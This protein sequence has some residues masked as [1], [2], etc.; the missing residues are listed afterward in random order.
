MGVIVAVLV[1]LATSVMADEP[2]RGLWVV[3]DSIT[4]PESVQRVV[5]FAA[6]HGFNTLFVQVRGRGD[7][8]Y[9]S[10]FVPGPEGYPAIP[11]IF[12]PLAA[13]V[14]AAHEHGIE[15]HAWCNIYLTASMINPPTDPQHLY[16]AHPS[17][18]M[19][20]R[21]GRNMA[22][23]PLESFGDANF[24]GAFL[25]PGLPEVRSY[26]ARVITEVLVS[27]DIDGIHLDY[28]R[29]PGRDFDF[30]YR[31]RLRFES[32]HGIDPLD[33]VRLG[34]TVD[35]TL[36]LA[37]HW[38]AFRADQIDEQVRGIARR[39]LISGRDVALS[40]AVKPD[41]VTAYYEFGQDW[42]GWLEEGIVDFV[43]PMC[44]HEETAWIEDVLSGSLEGVDRSR[45]VGGVGVYKV[46][47][48]VMLEQI[49]LMKQLGLAGYC[50]F[51]YTTFAEDPL[52]GDALER[53][54][55][56]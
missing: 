36:E 56:P 21:D 7:A 53:L 55:T 8:Y 10:Y 50:L 9:R 13:V 33:V 40:A 37:E 1:L 23:D 54:N 47:P 41:A 5:A 16:N 14:D 52:F 19:V 39:I 25:S 22:I 24:E 31:T 6:E 11:D 51:S 43:V 18:F 49:S 20:S 48:G 32:R 35:P 30:T 28:V 17:W 4:T 46:M 42:P 38:A 26:L 27:Y 34:M 44:Y 15:V 3:R 2:V 45:V 12:D 29:Y